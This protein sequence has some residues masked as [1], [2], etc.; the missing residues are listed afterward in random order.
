MW[1]PVG[2]DQPLTSEPTQTASRTFGEGLRA[3]KRLTACC[4]IG[5][6]GLPKLGVSSSMCSRAHAMSSH[7]TLDKGSRN[8]GIW[9]GVKPETM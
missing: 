3:I 2:H 6:V 1:Q 5:E 8:G 4:M 7:G 9:L